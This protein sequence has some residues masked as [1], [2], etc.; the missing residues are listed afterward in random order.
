LLLTRIRQ[1]ETKLGERVLVAADASNVA[2]AIEQTEAEYVLLGI[3]EDIGVRANEGRG[4]T[5][6][7]WPFFP[8][9]F[10]QP[11]EQRFPYRRER[12]GAGLF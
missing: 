11:A 10:S 7:A 9:E 1:F 2:A 6:T 12:A 5:G 3:P 8:K 4:G